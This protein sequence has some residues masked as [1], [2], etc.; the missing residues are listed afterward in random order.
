MEK[1]KGIIL[2]NQPITKDVFEMEIK[3]PRIAAL[4]EAGQFINISLDNPSKLLRRPISISQIKDTS[5]IIAYKINGEGTMELAKY[6]VGKELDILGPLG[7]GFPLVEK[8]SLLVCGGIGVAPM[9]ALAKNLP[10]KKE[11]IIAGRDLFN[12]LYEDELAKHGKIHIVTDD[13]SFG[14]KGNAITYL[15]ENPI[16][17]NVFYACGPE[18]M[19]KKLEELYQG[20]EG[21]LSYEARMAC[22]VGLCHGCVVG[23]KKHR[24]VCS[25]GPVFKNGEIGGDF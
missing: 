4:S 1:E 15:K 10:G 12:I 21:Y 6:E 16:D 17:F 3:L 24:C 2:S 11:I 25:D 9:L 20:K 7:H 19:L 8:K 23:E 13:G 22:G 14:A 18:I 5:L